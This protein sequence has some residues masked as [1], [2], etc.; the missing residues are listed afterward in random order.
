MALVILGTT[1][2][3]VCNQVFLEGADVVAFSWFES[4]T[5][6]L[7]TFSDAGIH[8]SCLNGHPNRSELQAV[9]LRQLGDDGVRPNGRH[10]QTVSPSARISLDTRQVVIAYGPLF[11]TLEMP[12]ATALSWRTSQF[13]E[14]SRDRSF[15]DKGLE[16]A[17]KANGDLCEC[18]FR[19][20]P[21][22]T[23][24]RSASPS[25][26]RPII[27]QIPICEGER[28]LGELSNVL[29]HINDE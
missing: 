8:F 21:Y 7:K 14:S 24:P 18:S 26:V 23:T 4:G 15:A 16:A 29:S 20:C 27:R 9:F 22:G 1:K 5:A 13:W 28:A 11:I 3:P 17:F 2:C 19:L 12:R 10:I 25:L 6:P